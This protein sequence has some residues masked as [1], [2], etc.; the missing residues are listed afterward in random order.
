MSELSETTEAAGDASADVAPRVESTADSTT[1][2]TGH[3]AVDQVL[4]RLA[5]L[6]DVPVD[7]HVSIFDAVHRDLRDALVAASDDQPG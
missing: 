7:Q 3:P 4:E 5:E 6:D 1:E 2:S